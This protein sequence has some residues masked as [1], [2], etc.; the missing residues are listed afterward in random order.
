MRL[1]IV[2]SIFRKEITEA[3]RDR[4]TLIVVLALPILIYPLV[5]TSLA[6]I[7]RT[8]EEVEDKRVSQVI[9]WGEPVPSLVAFLEKTNTVKVQVERE[10]PPVSYTHLRA[11]ETGRNL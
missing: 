11:H 3:L 7:A 8:Q 9:I 10:I 2:W 1:H 5:V 4:L 6:R